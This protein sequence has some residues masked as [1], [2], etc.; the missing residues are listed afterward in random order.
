[1]ATTTVAP[2]PCLLG[3]HQVVARRRIHTSGSSLDTVLAAYKGNPQ[4]AAELACNDNDP[5]LLNGASSIQVQVITGDKL[6]IVIDS[7]ANPAA[8]DSLNLNITKQ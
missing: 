6:T 8:T 5:T 1:M 3:L 7:K 4:T 2:K